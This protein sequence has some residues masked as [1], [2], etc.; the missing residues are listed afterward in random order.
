MAGKNLNG[1]EK[2]AVLLQ[3]LPATV[4]EK[5]L[6]HMDVRRQA[7]QVPRGIEEGQHTG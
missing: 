7:G 5:V 3:S 1:L 4:V 6:K 2:A